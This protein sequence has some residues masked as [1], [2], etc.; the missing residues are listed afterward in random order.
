MF[1]W[2]LFPPGAV[3]AQP[4]PS[5]GV[6]GPRAR[7]T[8]RQRASKALVMPPP[9]PAGPDPDQ[10]LRTPAGQRSAKDLESQ[11]PHEPAGLALMEGIASQ[12]PEQFPMLFGRE[13][14]PPSRTFCLSLD[15]RTA[16]DWS[17]ITQGGHAV[18]KG[19]GKQ[20]A[21]RPFQRPGRCPSAPRGSGPP[22]R[23]LPRASCRG[24][25][26]PRG[27]WGGI[28]RSQGR[29]SS[30][31]GQAGVLP[32]LWLDKGYSLQEIKFYSLKK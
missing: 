26:L 28:P 27:E 10:P 16:G 18:S 20:L 32:R 13:G 7:E 29:G 6:E 30:Q 24:G 8:P 31:R 3:S 2:V 1:S 22:H 4:N 14:R 5:S 17:G 11:W 12:C 19:S 15:S 23:A 21:E 25:E 9:P